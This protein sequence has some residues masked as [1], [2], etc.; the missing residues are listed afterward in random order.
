MDDYYAE[1][2]I[3]E[4]QIERREDRERAKQEAAENFDF[5]RD[6]GERQEVV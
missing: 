6:C 5:E 3:R 1:D 4:A 2:E